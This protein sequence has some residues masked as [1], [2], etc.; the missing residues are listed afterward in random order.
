ML[1]VLDR[2]HMSFDLYGNHFCFRAA[3][4]AGKKFKWKETIEL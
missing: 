3:D 1:T 2:P 4:R